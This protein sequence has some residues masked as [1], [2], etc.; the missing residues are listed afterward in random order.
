VAWLGITSA[1]TG[2]G[3]VATVGAVVT[4]VGVAVAAAVG[5][6]GATFYPTLVAAA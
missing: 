4:A 5:V 6:V 1:A 2:A 3:V